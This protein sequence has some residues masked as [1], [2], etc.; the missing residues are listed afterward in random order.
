M[1]NGVSRPLETPLQSTEVQRVGEWSW[2]PVSKYSPCTSDFRFV[3]KKMAT[4]STTNASTFPLTTTISKMTIESQ[5]SLDECNILCFFYFSSFANVPNRRSKRRQ[6]RFL[7]RPRTCDK[8]ERF[9]RH[10]FYH[11]EERLA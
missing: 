1:Q 11:Q 3:Q 9:H 8:F 2:T 4:A 10:K 5:F 6:H 7:Y